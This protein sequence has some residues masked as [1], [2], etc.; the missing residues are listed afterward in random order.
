LA[1]ATNDLLIGTL[2]CFQGREEEG[3]RG[4][5]LFWSANLRGDPIVN[6]KTFPASNLPIFPES[7]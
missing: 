3:K 2:N 5:F 6:T 1:T 4:N 7:S